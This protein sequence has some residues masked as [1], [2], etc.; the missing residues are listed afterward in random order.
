MGKI[1]KFIAV[2]SM[3]V[4]FPALSWYYL[5]SGLEYRRTARIAM[6]PKGT[7]QAALTS[8]SIKT[9]F[10][11]ATTCK[12]ST[13][14]IV[15]RNDEKHDETIEKIF[16]QFESSYNFKLLLLNG[17]NLPTLPSFEF[18]NFIVVEGSTSP[19]PKLVLM[20]TELMIRNEYS[21][22]KESILNL[23]SH[24]ALLVPKKPA[25]DVV[26]KKPIE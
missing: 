13:C 6:E 12:G 2:I 9:G 5:N 11:I 23:V 7:L 18:D 14:L 21:F 25:R 26:I 1:F 8:G 15:S 10:D 20:D 17:K 22:E 19:T 16:K 4:I 24:T 3:L